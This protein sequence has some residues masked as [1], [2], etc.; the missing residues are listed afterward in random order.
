MSG[1]EPKCWPLAYKTNCDNI[2][3][4]VRGPGYQD[5]ASSS[6]PITVINIQHLIVLHL[7]ENSEMEAN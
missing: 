2:S 7:T 4:K 6:G 1:T 3:K 5:A